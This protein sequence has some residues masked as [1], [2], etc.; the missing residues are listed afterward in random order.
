MSGP[1]P[2]ECGATG[3]PE[4]RDT[5]CGWF[6]SEISGIETTQIMK[7]AARA[8]QLSKSFTSKDLEADF[9]EIL[10][11]AKSNI[12]GYGN[13][14][15][16]YERFVKPSVVSIKQIAS[17]WAISS[18]LEEYDKNVNILFLFSLYL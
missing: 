10:S 12:Q 15:D 11:K 1:G 5:S 13:G 16:V 17:L 4:G 7:Y 18:M 2:G 8:M 14:K 3:P 9:V 6:F